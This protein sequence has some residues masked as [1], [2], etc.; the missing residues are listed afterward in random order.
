MSALRPLTS[1]RPPRGVIQP[2][3]VSYKNV[4]EARQEQNRL[5]E[6]K[7]A[8]ANAEKFPKFDITF[9]ARGA[10]RVVYVVRGELYLKSTPVVPNATPTWFKA[11]PA[12]RF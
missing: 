2:T 11:G 4:I 6:V 12:P 8:P 7:R 10:R 3:A 1:A 5:V 9:G